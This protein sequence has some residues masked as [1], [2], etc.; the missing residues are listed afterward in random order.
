M[1]ILENDFNGKLGFIWC[2]NSQYVTIKYGYCH[3]PKPKQN[4][5]SKWQII[6]H[7]KWSKSV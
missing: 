2:E 6:D 3:M 1:Q 4:F 5:S 7:E